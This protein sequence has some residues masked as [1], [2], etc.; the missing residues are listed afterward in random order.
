MARSTSNRPE[1]AAA[2]VVIP[3][4][5][6]V[7]GKIEVSQDHSPE[8]AA[9]QPARPPSQIA[10]S[11]HV[12]DTVLLQIAQDLWRPLLIS[13]VYKDSVVAGTVFFTPTDNTPWMQMKLRQRVAE[14]DCA[15][16]VSGVRAGLE[17][18]G[19]RPR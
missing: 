12:G 18:G 16:W 9:G 2:G 6:I 17:I 14:H 10:L 1:P 5:G 19:W 7:V 11:P 8:R 15:R 4:G 3:P 13:V